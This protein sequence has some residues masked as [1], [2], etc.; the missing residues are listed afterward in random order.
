MSV[1]VELNKAAVMARIKNAA[2]DATPVITNEFIKDANYYCREDTGEL[3]RSAI[4]ASRPEDGLA[5]WDTPYAK[6]MYYTG[7]PSL[8]RNKNASL[9]WAHKA[10]RKFKAK[11][12]TMAQ[13]ILDRRV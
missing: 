13:K 10:A 11:Y 5:V 8:D 3:E 2:A 7:R 6:R 9:M 12:Q 4:R 1:R